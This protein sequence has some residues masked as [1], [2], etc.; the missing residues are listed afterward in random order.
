V[1]QQEFNMSVT[2][3]AS[4]LGSSDDTNGFCPEAFQSKKL[5]RL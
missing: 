4:D 3:R 2:R 1:G 5:T